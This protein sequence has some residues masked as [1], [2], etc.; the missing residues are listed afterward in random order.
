MALRRASTD[1]RPDG[2][3]AP[4]ASAEKVGESTEECVALGQALVEAGQLPGV[5]PLPTLRLWRVRGRTSVTLTTI[6]RDP[7][8]VRGRHR[9]F[10]LTGT[11]GRC[12]V[13][14]PGHHGAA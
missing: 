2:S 12:L 13:R 9:R 10:P 7:A 1:K 5:D 4:S 14:R 6:R 11:G 8:R 3:D